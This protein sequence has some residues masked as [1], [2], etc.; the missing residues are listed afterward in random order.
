[1]ELKF[2]FNN[3][4]V[5]RK[6]DIVY[7]YFG[8]VLAL[9]GTTSTLI[10]YIL[11]SSRVQ[12][13]VVVSGLCVELFLLA[14]MQ[15]KKVVNSRNIFFVWGMVLII[16]SLI[17]SNWNFIP[18][19][20]YTSSILLCVFALMC[21][22]MEKLAK[23]ILQLF[24]I[25][26]IIYAIATIVCALFPS[27]YLNHVVNLFP[28]NRA[29]LI[30]MYKDGGMAGLTSHY[31][32]NGM[33]LATGLLITTAKY[34]AKKS[35][36]D[37]FTIGVF[38]VAL[39]LTGKRA[40][41]LFGVMAIFVLYFFSQAKEKRSSRWIKT[42]GVVLLV[43][44]FGMILISSVPNLSGFVTRFQDNL[45]SG[46]VSNGRYRLWDLAI[47]IFKEHPLFGI[48][49]KRYWGEASALFS[50]TST[51]YD[52]HNVYLQLLCEI[53]IIGF[54]VYVSWFI[55]LFVMTIQKY[56]KIVIQNKAEQN[57]NEKYLIG[58]SL[59][60]QT[61]FFL[62]CFTGNPLYERSMFIP[63]YLGCATTLFYT[64]R[65]SPGHYNRTN[66][67]VHHMRMSINGR[68]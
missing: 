62:Y 19:I 11:P 67:K 50:N 43:L 32:T 10:F 4:I 42:I 28:E 54:I 9:F 66:V 30:R 3:K 37:L 5:Y 60:F 64:Y 29:R 63:Y 7:W 52:T 65:Q 1:M 25:M 56:K 39:L 47:T 6:W 16:L 45:D 34:S 57:L 27:L 55:S 35:R 46:D 53:G 36:A 48:G 23:T 44:C 38:L 41:I 14:I 21:M 15:N 68:R 58:F 18:T 2:K 49:W 8:F 13:L 12:N 24:V 20:L 51:A 40:H 61:F 59:A 17:R 31:S 22:P 33:F 26:D